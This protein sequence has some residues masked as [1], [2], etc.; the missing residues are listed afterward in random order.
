MSADNALVWL[1]ADPPDGVAVAQRVPR[2]T[3][4]PARAHI[5]AH[6]EP[7]VDAVHATTHRPR[8]ALERAVK[9]RVDAA[10]AWVADLTNTRERAFLLLEHTAELRVFDAGTHDMLLHVRKGCCLYYR[11]PAAVKC[12]GCPLLS[13]EDRRRL[14]AGG[15]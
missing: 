10:V 9:D 11:T 1:G 3:D 6:L 2:A 15:G 14:V 8:Q 12:F 5:D 4:E 7:L 13:D